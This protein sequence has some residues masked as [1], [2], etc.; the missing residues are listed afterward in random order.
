[1]SRSRLLS[2]VLIR[3]WLQYE[4]SVHRSLN[5][6]S[7][8][9]VHNLRIA[10]QKLEAALVLAH[11]C[12]RIKNFPGFIQEIRGTRKQ[13]GPLRDLQ[14]ESRVLSAAG[15]EGEELEFFEKTIRGEIKGTQKKVRKFLKVLSLSAQKRRVRKIEFELSCLE[16]GFNPEVIKEKMVEV[17]RENREQL[18]EEL[19]KNPHPDSETLH[20]LRMKIKRFRYLLESF[21]FIFQRRHDDVDELKEIQSGLGSLLD[22]QRIAEDLNGRYQDRR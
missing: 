21:N 3:S 2:H 7:E 6:T 9:N 14:V 4:D 20:H 12:L 19:K 8:S 10:T 15:T 1:M 17:M 18:S 16:E 13:T 5:K 11:G 22:H